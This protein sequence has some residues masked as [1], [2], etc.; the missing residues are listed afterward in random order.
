MKLNRLRKLTASLAVTLALSLG[1]A[2]PAFAQTAQ[3][4]INNGL[5]AGSNLQFT[6]SPG[7]CSAAGSDANAKINSIV[8]TVVN[9]LSAV[10]GI[11]AV[12]MIIVGGFRYVTSG[13]NDTSVTA[14][15]NTILYAIIGLV[16]VA[17]AQIIVRFTLSKLTNT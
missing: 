6:S 1:L 7:Q 9:L 11:V 16:V 8:H 17:L 4:Q 5:C 14:A 10:V 3:Q 15:K 2:A 12:I 13:G